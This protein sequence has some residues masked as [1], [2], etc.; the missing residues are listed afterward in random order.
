MSS[1]LE[2]RTSRSR[3]SLVLEDEEGER[4]GREV[5]DERGRRRERERESTRTH[6]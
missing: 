5:S 2:S 3:M 1:F 6:A 4:G